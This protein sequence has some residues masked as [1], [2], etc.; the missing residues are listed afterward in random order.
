MELYLNDILEIKAILDNKSNIRSDAAPQEG[1]PG[2]IAGN[3]I[4]SVLSKDVPPS[5]LLKCLKN[6]DLFNQCM[7]SCGRKM[8]YNATQ[9][10]DDIYNNNWNNSTMIFCPTLG[11][12]LVFKK[13][14]NYQG[15]LKHINWSNI[16][17]VDS[18]SP[19]RFKQ[20]ILEKDKHQLIFTCD[21]E[22]NA[23]SA[24]K[25]ILTNKFGD[26]ITWTE[27]DQN[28]EI[29]VPSVI[30]DN[31]EQSRRSVDEIINAVVAANSDMY[32]KI[33]HLPELITQN[34]RKYK[35]ATLDG[36]NIK[37]VNNIN[38]HQGQGNIYNSIGELN[39]TKISKKT[40]DYST[41]KS[42]ININLPNKNE[43]AADYYKRYIDAKL[44]PVMS[45]V[46]VGRYLS[47]LNIP[48]KHTSKGN[49]YNPGREPANDGWICN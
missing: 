11:L 48:V 41:S 45:N 7:A 12:F 29:T 25:K 8:Y 43:S 19:P 22:E 26:N 23:I 30:S 40:K 37:V 36:M 20:I 31:F 49:I 1:L 5:I 3:I 13:I 15:I 27:V 32:T 18:C 33:A 35:I 17:D 16:Q 10:V 47:K 21:N 2:M 6:Q 9:A 24:I 14:E 28:V 44:V 4:L 46:V 39:N 42:W 38:V 34:G